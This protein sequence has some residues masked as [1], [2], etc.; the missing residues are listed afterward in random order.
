MAY[1]LDPQV[2]VEWSPER[3]SWLSI[4]R[5]RAGATSIDANGI[6]QIDCDES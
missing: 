5:L 6:V 4:S 2:T 1:S 3:Q